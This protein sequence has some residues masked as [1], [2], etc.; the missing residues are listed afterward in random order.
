MHHNTE[1]KIKNFCTFKSLQYLHWLL[2]SLQE[3]KSVED[4]QVCDA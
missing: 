1:K 3:S 2:Q 4:S